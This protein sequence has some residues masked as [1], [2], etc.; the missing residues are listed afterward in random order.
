M[1]GIYLI[2]LLLLF[3]VLVG[4]ALGCARLERRP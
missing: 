1:D 2:A 3:W 4:M